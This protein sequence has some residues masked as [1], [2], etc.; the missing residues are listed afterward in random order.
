MVAIAGHVIKVDHA[1]TKSTFTIED[2]SGS[3]DAVQW[4]DENS[5]SLQDQQDSGVVEGNNVRVIGSVRT[6]QDKRYVMVFKVFPVQ[7]NEEMDAHKLEI[8]YHKMLIRKMND[9]ENAAIGANNFGL[10]NSMMANPMTSG[11]SASFGNAKYDA[12]YKMV[13]GCDREEGISRDDLSQNLAGKMG[14]KDV[15]DGLEYL[16]NEGHVYSTVDEDHFK[17]TDS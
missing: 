16:S 13:S 10:S 7:S 12:I 4:N 6:Q 3:L 14:K 8:E 11:N 15:D 1:D 17:T 5:D 9:K 2:N